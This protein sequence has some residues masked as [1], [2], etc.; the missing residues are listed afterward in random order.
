[1][2]I[3]KT[4]KNLINIFFENIKKISLE[5]TDLEFKS[6]SFKFMKE[7]LD[8][9][10]HNLIVKI[11]RKSKKLKNLLITKLEKF[12][13]YKQNQI[14]NRKDKRKMIEEFKNLIEDYIFDYDNLEIR[15][16]IFKDLAKFAIIKLHK[17]LKCKIPD[18]YF[19]NKDEKIH[20]KFPFNH[21]NIL[22]KIVEQ[23]CKVIIE[24]KQKSK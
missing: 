20:E 22:N 7:K 23:R 21:I 9:E 5:Y 6:N 18:E 1:L 12:I 3:L 16:N 24:G 13:E 2:N 15:L 10:K 14:K 8:E 19:I 11:Q 17:L 4:N